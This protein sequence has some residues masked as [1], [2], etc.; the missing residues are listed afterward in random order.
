MSGI[1]FGSFLEGKIYLTCPQNTVP[2]YPLITFKELV[3]PLNC[4]F[5]FLTSYCVD[6]FWLLSYFKCPMHL[7]IHPSGNYPKGNSFQYS[8]DIKI[9]FP[10]LKTGF[11]VFHAKIMLLSYQEGLRFV[12]SSANLVDYDYGQVQNILFVQDLE[13]ISTPSDS[14]F[15]KDLKLFLN[16]SSIAPESIKFM[17]KYNWNKIKGKLVFSIPGHNSSGMLMLQRQ[18]KESLFDHDSIECQ[19]SSLGVLKDDWMK[20][21]SRGSYKIVFPTSQQ[22]NDSSFSFETIFF[23]SKDWNNCGLKDHFYKCTSSV[24]KGQALHSKVILFLKDQSIQGLY[25]GSHNLTISAWGRV[26]KYGKVWIFNYEL[27]IIIEGANFKCPFERPLI[28]YSSNDSPW[29]N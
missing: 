25:L 11:G 23:K 14:R 8:K 12:I 26:T 17:D 7:L 4:K 6:L 2:D 29:F 16:A 24:E 13:E 1:S 15:L 9:S 18:L 20:N 5:A 10:T 22:V 21:F 28:Q 3:D 27:G 19:C